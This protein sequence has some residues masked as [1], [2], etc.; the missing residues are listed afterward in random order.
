MPSL[1]K[2]SNSILST[3][4]R[5]SADIFKDLGGRAVKNY[6]QTGSPLSPSLRSSPIMFRSIVPPSPTG[7]PIVRPLAPVAL[8][9]QTTCDK[10]GKE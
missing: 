10:L 3:V 1:V 8:R 9:A 5:T 4:A 6:A 7:S 2:L